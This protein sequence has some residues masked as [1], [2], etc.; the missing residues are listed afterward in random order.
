MSRLSDIVPIPPPETFNLGLHSASESTMIRLLG[1][2]GRKTDDCSDPTGDFAQHIVNNV[3]VGPFRVRGL[4]VAVESLKQI[5]AE[6]KRQAPQV[7]DEVSTEELGMLCVRHRRKNRDVFS[8]H[9]W[10]TAID[11]KFGPEEVGQGKHATQRGFLSLFP[12]FNRFGWHW[13]AGFSGDSV[14]SMH[15]ELAEETIARMV[16]GGLHDQITRGQE[17]ARAGRGRLLSDPDLV[18]VVAGQRLLFKQPVRQPGVGAVQD[19]LIELGERIDLGPSAAN[20]GIFGPQTKAAVEDFQGGAGIHVDG[21]VGKDTIRALERA[22]AEK[23]K[24]GRGRMRAG[25][26]P[27]AEAPMPAG[28][29]AKTLKQVFNRGSPKPEFLQELVV[30]GKTAPEAIFADQPGNEKDIYASLTEELGPFGGILHRKACMLEVMRVLAGFESSWNFNEG[31]DTTNVTSVTPDTIEAGAWQ[32][33][34]NSMNF[35][36]ELK[37]LVR[38]NVGT[39]DGNAFQKAM[40]QNHPLAMEYIARLMRRTRKANGPLLKGKERRIFKP[41]FQG[42]KQSIYPWLSREAVAEFQAF[43]RPRSPI[44]RGIRGTPQRMK[45]SG[46]SSGA[47]A[48]RPRGSRK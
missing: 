10:G 7:H 33:S 27:A 9:S 22:L 14:D 26:K 31:R 6:L 2:P 24:P 40:K 8:N 42:E 12:I 13:G 36:D 20:R 15:F 25:E 17:I 39:L 38:A 16:V 47:L 32:V 21:Q 5:F 29:F 43:L 18:D 45:R 1:I 46:R 28:K 35:G 23:R 3:D 34:A 19:A 30:W 4:N 41:A 48:K 44:R 11:L 37:D